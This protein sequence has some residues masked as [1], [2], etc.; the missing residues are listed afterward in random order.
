[1]VAVD[2]IFGGCVSVRISND[3]FSDDKGEYS[4]AMPVVQLSETMKKR[5]RERSSSVCSYQSLVDHLT[6]RV[7]FK[8][9]W[10]FTE[11]SVR[12]DPEM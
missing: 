5:H 9:L 10:T 6:E 3:R 4:G 12:K 2:E 11:V 7:K 8:H 1:M